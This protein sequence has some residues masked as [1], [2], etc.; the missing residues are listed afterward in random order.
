MGYLPEERGLYR[1]MRV[2][3]I[4]VYF[5]RL[6]GFR[7]SRSAVDGWLDRFEL[8]NWA[9]RRVETLSKGM[10]QKVQFI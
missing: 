8:G 10:A 2:R 7:K 5:A 4:L 3:D 9:D 1:K 6:K